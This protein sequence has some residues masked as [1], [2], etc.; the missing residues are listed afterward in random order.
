MHKDQI[1]KKFE[2]KK[3]ENIQNKYEI[4]VATMIYHHKLVFVDSWMIL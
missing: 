2:V 3:R 1:K 4:V